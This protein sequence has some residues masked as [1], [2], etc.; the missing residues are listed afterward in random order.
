MMTRMTTRLFLGALLA[1]VCLFPATK[2]SAAIT[3]DLGDTVLLP[4]M[5]NQ[6]LTISLLGGDLI[7]GAEVFL[8]FR[9][10]LGA[11]LP[12]FQIV[13]LPTAVIA[14]GVTVAGPGFVFDGI[15]ETLEDAGS[16]TSN[17]FFSVAAAD[18]VL[19]PASGPLATLLVD[20]TGILSG[21]FTLV[22]VGNLGGFATS[23]TD[24]D[25]NTIPLSGVVG[26]SIRVVAIPEPSGLALLMV[27]AVGGL[28]WRHATP[29]VGRKS[30]SFRRA[31]SLSIC[32]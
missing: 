17:A 13:R 3:L 29:A 5:A 8:T 28:I 7:N 9:G 14:S 2:A 26:G 16:S 10:P 4:D 32:D 1:M 23:F 24:T 27:I 15:A 22:D 11:P 18:S 31:L 12:V 6:E 19:T 21:E 30:F 20:T 25:F